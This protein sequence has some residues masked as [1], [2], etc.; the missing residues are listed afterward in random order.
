MLY[1][2]DGKTYI[3][4]LVNKI[5]EVKVEKNGNDYDIKPTEG[6]T[7]LTDKIK[8][9]LVSITPKQAYER[10]TKLMKNSH[11]DNF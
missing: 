6:V 4:P 5:V 2:Y 1:E 11:K 10:Q 9:E 7:Y 8:K 3:K